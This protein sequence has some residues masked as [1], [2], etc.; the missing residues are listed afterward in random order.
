M[1]SPPDKLSQYSNRSFIHMDN[2]Q[3]TLGKKIPLILKNGKTQQR[4]QK[5][6]LKDH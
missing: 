4:K 5:V 6:I 2:L 1:I 3:P